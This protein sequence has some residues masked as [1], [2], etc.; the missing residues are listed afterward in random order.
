MKHLSVIIGLAGFL[1][2]GAIGHCQNRISVTDG[3][4]IHQTT[5]QVS[6]EKKTTIEAK[7]TIEVM[8]QSIPFSLKQAVFI[9]NK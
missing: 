9:R 4:K 1:F 6:K 3:Q 5:N 8:G 2:M 7:G